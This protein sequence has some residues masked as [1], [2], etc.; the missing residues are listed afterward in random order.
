MNEEEPHTAAF[1]AMMG[2]PAPVKPLRKACPPFRRAGRRRRKIIPKPRFATLQ[3]AKWGDNYGTAGPHP[4]PH[5]VLYAAYIPD[6]PISLYI[7]I[8]IKVL[9]FFIYTT[10][11]KKK[12]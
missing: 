11:T 9:L 2:K 8:F 7:S 6:F 4:A 3:D 10:Q 5:D 12:E 1:P